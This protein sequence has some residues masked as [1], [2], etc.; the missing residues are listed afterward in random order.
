M[1]AHAQKQLENGDW[2]RS[3]EPRLTIKPSSPTPPILR[4]YPLSFLD[5]IAPLVSIPLIL[6]YSKSTTTSSS[7]HDPCN[8]LDVISN[9]IKKSL[10]RTLTRFYPLAGRL[11]N[12]LFVHCS[13]ACVP[14]TETRAHCLVSELIADP[15]PVELNK[16]L[17]FGDVVGDVPLAIQVNFF[18]CCGVAV[19]M[20]M[21][22]EVGDFSL[23]DTFVNSWAAA[24][25]GDC[26]ALWPRLDAA[27][28]FPPTDYRVYAGHCWNN[29]RPNCYKEVYAFSLMPSID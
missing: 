9:H 16:L 13:D 17:P 21:F 18:D 19:S 10:S 24:A 8:Q 4:H 3:H 14:Y 12:S 6:F 1:R 26:D 5:Q 2:S 27:S 15:I 20:A 11:V 23:L 25:S 22:H 7:V 28:L 29:R